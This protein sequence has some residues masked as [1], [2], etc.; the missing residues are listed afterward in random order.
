MVAQGRRTG[1]FETLQAPLLQTS[2]A[3]SMEARALCVQG[4][5]EVSSSRGKGTTISLIIPLEDAE[6]CA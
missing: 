1:V 4:H 5:F 2:A 6:P 3:L